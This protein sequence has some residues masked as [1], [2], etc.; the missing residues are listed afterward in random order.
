MPFQL[1][2]T[3]GTTPIAIPSPHRATWEIVSRG[4]NGDGSPRLARKAVVTW[5]YR[6]PISAADFQKF[7]ANRAANGQ[8]IFETWQRPTGAVAGAFVKVR[9]RLAL[10]DISGTER[11][12]E[13]SSVSF[14][15]T[16]V[17]AY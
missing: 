3:G 2:D 5:Q 1:Y 8:V 15:F 9:G 14:K 11:D 13:F 16:Q 10:T 4:I 7:V 17:E 12:G 6:A